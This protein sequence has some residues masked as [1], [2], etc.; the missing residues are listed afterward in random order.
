[1]PEEQPDLANV[2]IVYTNNVRLQMTFS[3]FKI[4]FGEII[5][6]LPTGPIPDL[7]KEMMVAQQK[8]VDRVCIIISPDL[9]PNLMA[10]L[11]QGIQKYQEQFGALRKPPQLA[12]PPAPKV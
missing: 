6:I 5:P 2:P 3:D 4:F 7:G 9:I 12:Q 10:G 11:A 1:M 8:V